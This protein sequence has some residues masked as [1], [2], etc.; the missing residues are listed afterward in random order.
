ME[1]RYEIQEYRTAGGKTRNAQRELETWRFSAAD[2]QIIEITKEVELF[3]CWAI[4]DHSRTGYTGHAARSVSKLARLA[5][6]YPG[7]NVPGWKFGWQ[8]P[9]FPNTRPTLLNFHLSFVSR[10]SLAVHCRRPT[11]PGAGVRVTRHPSWSGT[12]EHKTCWQ[13]DFQPFLCSFDFNYV[14]ASMRKE[15]FTSGKLWISSV[16][17]LSPVFSC[18]FK[19]WS[20]MCDQCGHCW[21]EL[22]KHTHTR[23]TYIRIWQSWAW[24]VPP[25]VRW[26]CSRHTCARPS[27]TFPGHRWS[28]VISI[29]CPGKRTERKE[30]LRTE[31]WKQ[32]MFGSHS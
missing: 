26:T 21:L 32:I 23:T 11:W 19:T 6:N 5:T 15:V 13:D 2:Y 18:A 12:S 24:S 31:T 17:E 28:P 27:V 8:T 1:A 7:T 14:L 30:R 10:Y 29:A 3:D 22:Y 9:K 25:C 20:I 4:S 16:S